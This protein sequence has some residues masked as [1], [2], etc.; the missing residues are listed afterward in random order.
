MPAAGGV[1]A[2]TLAA[3]LE[4]VESKIP[5]LFDRDDV[6][7]SK[8]EKRPGEE[9]SDISMRVP[10][11]IHPS[12]VV[13]QF[14]S[15]GQDLGLG[16]SPDY[17]K[18]EI[19][20]V[21]LQIALQWTSRRKWATDS[22]RKA[23]LNT[24]RRDLAS[25]MQE[26]RRANDSLCMTAGNGVLA[27]IT[28][29]TTVAGVDTYTLTT[30]GFGA[31][32]LRMKQPLNVWDPTLSILRNPVGLAGQVKIIYLDLPNKTVQ[33][34]NSPGNVQA[35]DLIAFGGIPMQ[36]PPPTSL[37]GVFYHASNASVGTWLGF[38]R[39]TTPEIRANR[40]QAGGSLSLP[41]PRLAINKIGDRIGIKKRKKLAA[42]MHPCQKQQYEEL[43]FEV[44]II[45]KEAK[46][47][48]LDLYFG[49]SFQMA[50]CPVSESYSWDKTRIDF[51]DYELW[52][53]AE[54]YPPRWYKDENGLKFFTTRG[55]SG[56]VATGNLAYITAAWNLYPNNPAGVS[57]IDTL[58][59]ASGY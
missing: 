13:Q 12:A 4:R 33:V 30:D 18:A 52:G 32:L 2:G 6:F 7:Y 31:R 59:V 1:A 57:Y 51:V 41:M 35:G 48:G 22:A 23:V 8:I 36:S 50:G 25:A 14:S 15:D 9:I 43:G 24:F 38:N 19:N 11:E 26:F 54:F 16:D 49:D 17:D 29:V 40:V 56:G 58:T 28:T 20:T 10:L 5:I 21:E 34:S 27:T 3:E 55:A 42:W 37:L 39:A 47:Q 53:R 46:E 44:S 45:N